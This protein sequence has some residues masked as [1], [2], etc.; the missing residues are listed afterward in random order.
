MN[1]YR[2]LKQKVRI[3]PTSHLK[4]EP[5]NLL[6]VGKYGRVNSGKLQEN[7]TFVPVAIYSIQDKKMTQ[8][9]KKSMLHD[10]DVL[11]KVGKHENLIGLVGTS[12]NPQMINV[13]LELTSMN[14]KDLLLSSR[15]SLPGKFSN[16][17]ETKALSIALQVCN[18]MAHLESCKV[19]S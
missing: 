8:E 10:L 7:D 14:L 16:M 6:G 13:V 4:I 5:T 19:R 3:I 2:S 15:D 17:S 12:E 11:I 9:S 1:H 18:G